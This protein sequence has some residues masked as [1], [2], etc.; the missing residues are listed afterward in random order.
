MSK[1]LSGLLALF[2]VPTMALGMDR[3]KPFEPDTSQTIAKNFSADSTLSYSEKGSTSS[4][5]PSSS[6]RSDDSESPAPSVKPA[7][8]NDDDDGDD[9]NPVSQK[10]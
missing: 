3:E 8:Q 6:E 2:L 5:T 1:K 9:L 4:W 10:R 7:S